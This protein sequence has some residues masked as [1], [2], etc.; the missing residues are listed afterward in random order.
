MAATTRADAG[1]DALEKGPRRC[2]TCGR[3]MKRSSVAL[4]ETCRTSVRAAAADAPVP[5]RELLEPPEVGV[6]PVRAQH[7]I[8][9]PVPS[10]LH[11][12]RAIRPSTGA[13]LRTIGP[14]AARRRGTRRFGVPVAVLQVIG[15]TLVIVLAMGAGAAIAIALSS[16]G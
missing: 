9:I 16:L 11:P 13:V 6:V 5:E 10:R 12:E 7:D 4:C 8:V 2:A 15:V 1:P 3:F 14:A